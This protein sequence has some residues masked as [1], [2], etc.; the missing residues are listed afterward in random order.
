[1]RRDSFLAML[2]HELRNPLGAI[3][4]A[5]YLLLDKPTSEQARREALEVI[6]RQGQLMSRLLD[7]LLDVS[8]LTQDKIRFQ[9][10][11]TDLVDVIEEAIRVSSA[12]IKN[13]GLRLDAELSARPLPV[14]GDAVRLQQMVV[15]LLTNA[16]KYTPAGGS[17]KVIASR[18]GDEAEIRVRDTG[19]GIQPD[20]L[21]R[22]F[23]LFVQADPG[24][25]RSE[26]GMGVGLT[27]VRTIV[28]RHGG[29]VTARSDGL[30]RGSEFVVQLPLS[31]APLLAAAKPVDPSPSGRTARRRRDRGGQSRQSPDARDPAPPGRL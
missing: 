5:S 7:D 12:T 16:A 19:I 13:A 2:S 17:V 15:N 8:R 22:I 10:D 26:G 3:L 18:D 29:R 14:S 31:R 24:L 21:E 30:N 11:A 9:N 25:D 4:N 23:E 6:R 28:Q 1:M 27:L 20:M